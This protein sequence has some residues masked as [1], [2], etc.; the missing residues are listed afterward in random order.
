MYRE[1]SQKGMSFLEL[2][3]VFAVISIL[4]VMILPA[5]HHMRSKGRQAT[6]IGNQRQLS[7]AS[8]LYA[9]E[10][11]DHL[12]ISLAGVGK[13][14][15]FPLPALDNSLLVQGNVYAESVISDFYNNDV[16]LM[17]C[18]ASLGE[19]SY[20]LNVIVAGWRLDLIKNAARTVL[21]A[22]SNCEAI[23]S[24]ISEDE[25]GEEY[26]EAIAYRHGDTWSHGNY[27]IAIAAYVDGHIEVFG[28]ADVEEEA[29]EGPDGDDNP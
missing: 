11:K 28:E 9:N 14:Q 20:G 24:Y 15:Y 6:C 22:D 16:N 8:L 17:I 27:A 4:V 10:W 3:M 2:L 5:L 1:S 13:S 21:L 7:V 26:L 19:V 18:P 29:G 25:D 12:P 23:S